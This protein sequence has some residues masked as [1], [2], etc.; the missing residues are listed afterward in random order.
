VYAK[1]KCKEVREWAKNTA[2][3][4]CN[5]AKG[6]WV[7]DATWRSQITT[8]IDGTD[9]YAVETLFD[10]MK[11]FEN[12]K[13]AQ[14]LEIGAKV[15]YPLP[16][17]IMS[18]RSYQW[19]RRI[20]YDGMVSKPITPRRGI[21]AGSAFAT[22]E[23]WCM[24]KPAIERMQQFHPT[25]V[26][27]LH[28]DD[29]CMTA[30]SKD[31]DTVVDLMHSVVQMA[32]EEFEVKR[33]LPFA[34]GKTFVV[35][36]HMDLAKEIASSIDGA[37]AAESVKKLGIDYSLGCTKN[38]RNSLMKVHKGR[39]LKAVQR[40]IKL[41]KRLKGGAQG[42]HH[43]SPTHGSLRGRALQ[44]ASS[45]HLHVAKTSC[46]VWKCEANWGQSQIQTTGSGHG[47]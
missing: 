38:K 46:C 23:L 21:G 18:L 34:A 41:R 35:G 32:T 16:Q 36:S 12:V 31:R 39:M 2:G 4:Q 19:T 47:G 6:R 8:A 11:A 33:S 29:L 10:L 24:L 37:T 42:I 20:L 27:C 40:A 3:Y 44:C 15:G 9:T 28:V 43:R 1:C 17:L 7:G 45:R 5:T 25:V 26:I 14:L 30:R 13:R 22:F